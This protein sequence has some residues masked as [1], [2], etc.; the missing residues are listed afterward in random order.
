MN[1]YLPYTIFHAN[2]KHP[3]EVISRVIETLMERKEY[4]LAKHQLELPFQGYVNYYQSLSPGEYNSA[5]TVGE[6]ECEVLD[7]EDRLEV[8]DDIFAINARSEEDLVFIETPQ[9]I[10]DQAA[11]RQQVIGR[12]ENQG[13][14]YRSLFSEQDR[15]CL[16]FGD[17]EHMTQFGAI[18]ASVK[19]AELLADMLDIDMDTEALDFYRSYFFQDYTFTRDGDQVNVRLIPYDEAALSDLYFTWTLDYDGESV[20]KNEGVGLNEQTFLLSEAE[21]SYD[22]K[23]IIYNMSGNYFLRGGIDIVR[24]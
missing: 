18:I 23:L 22:L 24:E 4:L 2:W 20:F 15:S 10:N 11:C 5:D 14:T 13:G 8:V 17:R 12:I 16:W 6:A 21:G 19:T 3:D 1:F 7:L 9:F